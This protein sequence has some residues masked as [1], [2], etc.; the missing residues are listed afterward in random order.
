MAF[1]AYSSARGSKPS[2]ASV[3]VHYFS[4]MKSSLFETAS[5][6]RQQVFLI[7]TKSSEPSKLVLSL[8]YL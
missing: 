8:S 4:A 6:A 2:L 7:D 3:R 5:G 1:A